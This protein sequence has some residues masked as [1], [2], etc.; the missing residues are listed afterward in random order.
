MKVTKKQLLISLLVIILSFSAT[1][2]GYCEI[3]DDQYSRDFGVF[4]GWGSGNLKRQDD[5]ETIP[6]Y[7][8]FGFDAKPFFKKFKLNPPG[9]IR[10]IVE[11]FLNTVVNPDAN[12]EAGCDFILKYS[13]PITQRLNLY[14]EIGPGMMYTS[15]H[16][17]EQGTQF[18]FCEQGG[19]G[20]SFSFSE[21]KAINF[22]YRYR[23]FSNLGIEEPNGGVDMEFFL[24]GITISY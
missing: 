3:E 12:I 7:F 15:Q 17:T 8:Q 6:L 19:V 16:T 4:S 22:G 20:V 5:Y 10:F 9:D 1:S 23:H 18:N 13:H 11:P 24:C 14:L 21:N 2:F